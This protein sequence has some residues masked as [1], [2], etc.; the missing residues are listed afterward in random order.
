MEHQL[1]AID[2]SNSTSALTSKFSLGQCSLAD[3]R[4]IADNRSGEPLRSTIT[5]DD[6]FKAQQSEQNGNGTLFKLG[7]ESYQFVDANGEPPFGGN[8]TNDAGTP[9]K[10]AYLST[11]VGLRIHCA[12]GG[13]E[14]ETLNVNVNPTLRINQQNIK[15]GRDH[16]GV[17]KISPEPGQ[18]GDRYRWIDASLY[19][20]KSGREY[21]IV[22]ALSKSET[23]PQKGVK[24]DWDVPDQRHNIVALRHQ[25]VAQHVS[26]TEFWSLFGPQR[27]PSRSN[28]SWVANSYLMEVQGQ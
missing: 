7:A 20:D 3:M 6:P 17:F 19:S 4:L 5:F 28:Q 8:V 9:R 26:N 1:A 15:D 14:E 2:S 21:L 27:H 11:T 13:I 24:P 18:D 22:H 12:H 16:R 23:Q 10:G 25:S